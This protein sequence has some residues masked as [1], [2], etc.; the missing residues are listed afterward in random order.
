VIPPPNYDRQITRE[1]SE[2]IKNKLA[3][4]GSDTPSSSSTALSQ[5]STANEQTSSVTTAEV[6]QLVTQW[7]IAQQTARQASLAYENASMNLPQGD[8][9]ITRLKQLFV[10]ASMRE[11]ELNTKYHTALRNLN[12][13]YDSGLIG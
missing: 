11:Q 2:E 1:E 10:T 6:N 9:E 7:H 13:N 5:Q 3:K 12:S 4:L 8:P